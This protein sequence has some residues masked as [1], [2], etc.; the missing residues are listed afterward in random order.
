[1]LSMEA[2]LR[3]RVPLGVV[4]RASMKTLSQKPLAELTNT[5]EYLG[6]T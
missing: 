4:K 5:F 1:M 6:C 2:L 3:A